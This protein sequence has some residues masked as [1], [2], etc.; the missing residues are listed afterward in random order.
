MSATHILNTRLYTSH[1]E[2]GAKMVAFAGYNMPINY[3]K[4]IKYEYS[5]VRN[6]AGIFDVSHMG[7]IKVKGENAKK[8]LQK[9]TVNDIFKLEK[10][11]AQYNLICNNDGGIKDDIIL[12][13]FNDLEFLLIVNASNCK[14]IFKWMHDMKYPNVNIKNKSRDY[15]LIAVQGP[16]SRKLLSEVFNNEINIKFYK[17][18]Y[19]NFENEKLLLS[20]TGYTGEL[21]FEILGGHDLIFKLWNKFINIG[22]E[23]CGLA[24][25]DILRMEM[26][27]CLYGNDIN[28]DTSPI[29]AGLSWV[30]ELS[31][32]DFIGKDVLFKQKNGKIEKKLIS[33]KMLDKCIPRKGYKIY[34]NQN[35]KIG[36]VT[37][38]TYS[39]GLEYGIGIGYIESNYLSK[40]L[41]L[42]LRNKKYKGMIV[43]P[44]FIKKFSLHS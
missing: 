29:E 32:E 28:E 44:P 34:N 36:E 38:G 33:F 9:L 35:I 6:K 14:K 40:N 3:N 24:V 43:K 5:A 12:Y 26:K 37:S 7:E 22:T 8:F 25:R 31:K 1:I 2:L 42:D 13:M 17:H 15:S 30:V 19:V 10:G 21:G 18:L 41:Y 39:I 16:E 4:G 11:D 23:P 27:Y 20:R